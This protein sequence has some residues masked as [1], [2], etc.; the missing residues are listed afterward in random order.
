[1]INHNERVF[2]VSRVLFVLQ[3]GFV[4]SINSLASFPASPIVANFGHRMGPW[5]LCN[6]GT[7]ALGL[8]GYAFGMLDLLPNTTSLAFSYILR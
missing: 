1:M 7:M 2:R 3:Y 8:C 4:F 5:Y 6:F